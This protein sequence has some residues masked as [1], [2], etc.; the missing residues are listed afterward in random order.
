NETFADVR[1]A[2]LDHLVVFFRDQVL[3][4]EQ[5][6]AFTRRF[7]PLHIHPTTV[8]MKEHPEIIEVIK[9]PEETINWG[10]EWHTDLTALPEPPM[11]STLYAREIPPYSGD[12][13]FANMYLAYDALSPVM[14]GIVDGLTCIHVQDLGGYS[15]QRSMGVIPGAASQAEHPI[16]RTHP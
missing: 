3:T 6:K 4:P 10:D 9:E 15:K 11:G 14:K 5:Q 2:F 12:T 7:G 16:V 1:H 13:M 8:A